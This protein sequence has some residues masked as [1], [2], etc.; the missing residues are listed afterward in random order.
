[1]TYLSDKIL[2]KMDKGQ[3]KDYIHLLYDVITKQSDLSAAR[4]SIIK[5]LETLNTYKDYEMD[6][7]TNLIKVE[8]IVEAFAKKMADIPEDTEDTETTWRAE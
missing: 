8:N 5:T 7:N 6:C 4:K 2:N 3:L 1:M